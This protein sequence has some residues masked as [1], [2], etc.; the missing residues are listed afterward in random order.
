MRLK[1]MLCAAVGGRLVLPS[2][3]V[4]Q[5][6]SLLKTLLVNIEILST[7]CV[8]LSAQAQLQGVKAER[9]ALEAQRKAEAADSRKA[10]AEID[11]LQARPASTQEDDTPQGALP[12]QQ[13]WQR[14]R[15]CAAALDRMPEFGSLIC[16]CSK[17]RLPSSKEIDFNGFW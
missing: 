6:A 12:T 17:P 1:S 7:R 14:K 3:L 11:F 10:L 13:A 16:A 8:L 15:S 9:A 4:Q 5:P 2:G